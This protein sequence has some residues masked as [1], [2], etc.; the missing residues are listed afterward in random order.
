MERSEIPDFVKR[1]RF[2]LDL[3]R[4]A[5]LL[6]VHRNT[7]WAWENGKREPG[8]SHIVALKVLSNCIKEF[9]IGEEVSK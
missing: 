6:G 3:R 8:A 2:P 5:H 7:L 9:L 4:A 1:A